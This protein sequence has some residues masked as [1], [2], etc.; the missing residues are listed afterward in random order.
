[1]GT[2]RLLSQDLQSLLLPPTLGRRLWFSPQSLKALRPSGPQTKHEDNP[3]AGEH[4]L[5]DLSELGFGA[6]QLPAVAGRHPGV[7][8]GLSA[9]E[10][11]L[12][13]EG[14]LQAA[15]SDV[16]GEAQGEA[17][18]LLQAV[19]SKPAQLPVGR[20]E[21]ATLQC[22]APGGRELR[23]KVHLDVGALAAPQPF[24]QVGEAEDHHGE[25][26]LGW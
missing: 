17:P 21:A 10:E 22:R 2:G 4:C 1:M 6:R 26:G 3:P 8:G 14:V 7:P 13:H 11:D 25:R 24:G 9:G 23:Q 5:P 16:D 19:P 12:S 18:Q 15:T 20:V